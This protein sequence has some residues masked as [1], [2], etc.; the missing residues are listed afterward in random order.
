KEIDLW[1][2]AAHDHVQPLLGVHMLHKDDQAPLWTAILISPWVDSGNLVK[3][4]LTH[5]DADRKELLLQVAYAVAYLHTTVGI[6]H[7]DI[8]AEN[9]LVDN[10]GNTKLCDFGLSTLINKLSE[11]GTTS[12]SFRG[13][14]TLRHNAPE[15]NMDEVLVPESNT[16]YMVRSKSPATDVYAY[17]CLILQVFTDISPWAGCNSA[18]II[19]KV[20]NGEV[21]PY[22]FPRHPAEVRG[23]DEVWYDFCRRCWEKDPAARPTMSQIVAALQTSTS[24]V[25]P[26][27]TSPSLRGQSI[28]TQPE[29]SP[30]AQ[31]HSHTH[32]NPSTTDMVRA[33][34]I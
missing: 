22:P 5:P 2:K 17:G 31:D 25:L 10:R 6:A 33:L 4:L 29:P 3:Y 34:H 30:L 23:F 12:A 18:Q 21:P 14:G 1:R 32:S 16:P 26:P 27:T 11:D 20:F 19:A 13:K 28:S 8:K 15:L 24:P 7:G 9:V